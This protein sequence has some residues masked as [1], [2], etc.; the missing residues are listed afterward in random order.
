MRLYCRKRKGYK[1]RR[2]NPFSC[3]KNPILAFLLSFVALGSL[4]FRERTK[5]V[6][7]S[8]RPRRSSN[9][10]RIRY[11]QIEMGKLQSEGST[12]IKFA[13]SAHGAAISVAEWTLAMKANK[14]DEVLQ[15][16]TLLG[17]V[18]FDSFF[19]ELPPVISLEHARKLPM[20]FVVVHAPD[21]L[22]TARGHSSGNSIFRAYLKENSMTSVFASSEGDA[23]LIAPVNYPTDNSVYSDIAVFCRS[24]PRMQRLDF[25][26][27]VATEYLQCMLNSRPVWL[28]SGKSSIPW[29]HVRL[30]FSPKATMYTAYKTNSTAFG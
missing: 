4:R 13:A 15:W 27:H 9:T 22:E 14:H 23:T 6:V 28:S 11:K 8:L 26:H 29:A 2:S 7:S 25:W 3:W 21:I 20:E 10:K 19:F 30:N 1:Y 17:D 16:Y 24:A 5:R 18:K 12:Y